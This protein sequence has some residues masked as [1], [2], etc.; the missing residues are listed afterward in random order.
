MN[1]PFIHRDISWLSFNYRVLQEA[2]DPSVPLLERLKFLAI[3]SSNLD[4]FFRI[5]VAYVRNLRK[6]GKKTKR[7]LD[8]D[9]TELL[10]QINRLVNRQQEEFSATFKQIVGELRTNGIHLLTRLELNAEQ[11]A[12]V[13]GYFHGNLLPF[14]QPMLLVGQKIRPFLANA[15]I[16]LAVHLKPKGK[17]KGA[18]EYALVKVPSDQLP[19]FVELPA[20]SG[21]SHD[22]I[23]LD[24]IVRHSVSFLFPGYDIQDTYSIKS[25]RDAE[26]Y[27][28]DEMQGDLISKVKSSLS[29]RNVG[30][31]TRFVYDR[32]MP[33]HLLDYLQITFGLGKYDIHPEGRYH[34]NFDFFRFPDFGL[35]Q[36][37]YKPLPPLPVPELEETADF[38]QLISGG[39]RMLHYPYQSYEGVVRFFEA[40][41]ED[42]TVTHIKII[43]YRT[44]KRSRILNALIRAVELGKQVSVF[45]EI[46]ARFDEANNLE[47]GEKLQKA[48]VRVHYSFPGVKVHAKLALVRREE[49]GG[50]KL[51]SYLSTGNFHEDTAKIYSDFGIFT[52]DTRLTGEVSRLFSFLE[53]VKRPPQD[54][55]HL[56]IGQFNLRKDILAHIN[57][58]I[59]EA[60]KGRPA[61]LLVKVNSLEDLEIIEKLY[62]ASRAG[63]EIRLVVR[64]ICCLIPEMKDFSKN[65]TA[66]S[67]VDRFLEHARVFVFHHAGAEKMFLS[68]ADLMLRNLSHRIEAAFPVFDPE[69]KKEILQIL[70]FQLAD[71]VKARVLDSGQSNDYRRTKSDIP[72]RS[73]IETYYW[74]KRRLDAQLGEN[75]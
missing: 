26:L 2:K 41:A 33:F 57:F 40:A 64:G 27:I 72:I 49:P 9:P 60:K 28:D 24:D 53:N 54:F 75:Q 23:M 15:H 50:T 73:Q 52:S 10:K 31:P 61:R 45:V 63:V 29:K 11:R 21:H 30:P 8:F 38:F 19:R 14:V 7:E 48:G 6:V 1:I 4:E 25:S 65:I 56:L 18:S 13:E 71:N 58:E 34:N 39:D 35:H 68:S 66:I 47:W 16:Y 42:P 32:E 51:Y 67:I 44:G 55:E 20:S 46:K 70:D 43:Q 69:I 37:R 36:L 17:P 74:L 22:L 62:E 5:R 59:D 3:Y 12:F